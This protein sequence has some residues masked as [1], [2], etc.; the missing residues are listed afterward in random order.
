MCRGDTYSIAY[1]KAMRNQHM[2]IPKQLQER[3]TEATEEL[4]QASQELNEANERYH[5]A[6]LARIAIVAELNGEV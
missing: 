2:E 1:N 5:A 4:Q 6:V 3:W